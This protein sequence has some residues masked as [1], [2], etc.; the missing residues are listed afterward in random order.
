MSFDNNVIALNSAAHPAAGRSAA[1]TI[2]GDGV[3]PHRTEGNSRCHLMNLP[4]WNGACT[5]S[6]LSGIRTA[7]LSNKGSMRGQM[8]TTTT[9][10][11]TMR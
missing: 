4:L 8:A 1:E 7:S 2:F 10:A 5:A 3:E 6:A 9:S 11:P